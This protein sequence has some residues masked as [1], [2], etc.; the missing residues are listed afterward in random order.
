MSSLATEGDHGVDVNV[1]RDE[2]D[3]EKRE[4]PSLTR[5]LTVGGHVAHNEIYS[6]PKYH[7]KV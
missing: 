6:L 5:Q 2:A 1:P 4:T 3:D 7:R